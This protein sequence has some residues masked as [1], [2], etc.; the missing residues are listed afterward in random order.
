[1]RLALALLATLFLGGTA[2]AGA[3]TL[4]TAFLIAETAFDPHAVS[5]LYSNAINDAIFDPLLKYDYL[6]RP[7][8][9]RPNTAVSLP[10]VSTD[11]RTYTFRVRPGIRF[12][13]D[14]AFGGRARELTAHDYAYSLKRL[15][16]PAV[17]SP[18]MWYVEGKIVGGDEAHA[19][20]KRTG[21]FD[22]DAPLAGIETP[23]RFTLRIRLKDTD[24][25]F[26]YVFATVQTAAIAR[27]VVERYGSD[28]G[29][30]PVGTGPF[31][32]AAWKRSHQIV[33]VRNPDFREERFVADPPADD[34]E[35]Q[36][37]LAR[38][39]G[40]RL[41]FVDRVEV[42]II[43]ESQPRWLAL[44]NGD[45]DFGNVPT[46]YAGAAFPGGKLA[47]YLEKK[48]MRGQRFVETDLVYVYFN[49][50]NTI[51]G[52]YTPQHVALRRAIALAYNYHED[53]QVIRNGGA[54]K[55][56]SAIP[57]GVAGYDPGFRSAQMSYDPARA[58]ALLDLAGYL[59]RDG[60][61]F[62]ENPDGSPLT[63]EMASEPDSTSRLFRELWAKNLNAI[64]L[65]VK[66]R[67]AKWPD[68]NKEAKAGKL[69][70]WQLAWSADYPDGE[71][72][73]QNL[74]GPN[75]GQSNY[76]NFRLP[77]F[78]RLYERA[79]QMPPSAQREKLYGE[80][81]RLVAAYSPWIPQT[82]RQRSEVAHGWVYGYRKHP[83][84]P[85]VWMYIDIDEPQR[86]RWKVGR[87]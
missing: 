68:N 65:R 56:E 35:L 71:N 50:E 16:D 7:V 53:I 23:D 69:Q 87:R 62:R 46:E 49:M 38:H 4:R 82:H 85:Q 40:R 41:P 63:L 37:I 20:A 61:G 22:Y 31:K 66:F 86:E 1:M 8:R 76:A 12:T 75:A 81:N 34:P 70:M 52:G 45:L 29:A 17:K 6:A 39:K 13:P 11:G 47:P 74:Y 42:S 77:A 64:G 3:K 48:G 73:L 24:F 19:A 51:V 79:R 21:R 55:A 9:L 30:H 5:D 10:E 60:D 57:P 59:D 83:I 43:E 33:L 67:I 54:V 58:R 78:D 2:T 72:F 18:W 15:Y 80:M 28:I 32:L 84:Y 14:P 44:Q 26:I 36:A 25:N 27:E